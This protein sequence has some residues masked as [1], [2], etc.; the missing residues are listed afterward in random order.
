MWHRLSVHVRKP[1]TS[2]NQTAVI[3]PLTNTSQSTGL[4][5][6]DLST[7]TLYNVAEEEEVEPLR[8]NPPPPSPP[9][10]AHVQPSPRPPPHIQTGGGGEA[11]L[12]PFFSPE[13]PPSS[14]LPLTQHLTAHSPQEGP[15]ARFGPSPIPSPNPSRSDMISL[16][17]NGGRPVYHQSPHLIQSQPLHLGDYSEPT[18]PLEDEEVEGEEERFGL[19]HGYMYDNAQIHDEEELVNIKMAME[20]SLALMPPSPFRDSAGSGSPLPSSPVSES[21]LCTPPSVT[22]ASV[23]LR[24]YKQSS[25]TL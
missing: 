8:Y 17:G 19:L 13:L 5:F 7:K 15:A 18:S 3:K 20:D 2:S 25:S 23:I 6:S 12:D 14:P 1:E 22:Y 4:D 21:V 16:P 11:D 10:T 24:D 9:M